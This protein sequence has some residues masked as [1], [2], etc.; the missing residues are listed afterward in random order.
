[1]K[2]AVRNVRIRNGA[3]YVR[4]R[5]NGSGGWRNSGRSRVVRTTAMNGSAKNRPNSA[6]MAVQPVR[7]SAKRRTISSGATAQT[8]DDTDEKRM[9]HDMSDPRS[10]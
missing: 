9:R 10:W 5:L 7:T 2:S 1:M 4:S 3:R 6:A 8:S